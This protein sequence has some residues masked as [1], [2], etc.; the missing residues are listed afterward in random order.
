MFV[1]SSA[2]MVKFPHC[3]TMKSN[4][5][6][7][8]PDEGDAVLRARRAKFALRDVRTRAWAG[9]VVDVAATSLNRLD[10]V[11]RQ[12]VPDARV[13]LSPLAGMDIAGVVS[14]VGESVIG[15]EVGDRVV[16]DLLW[17][18]SMKIPNWPHG[19]F[20]VSRYSW[21]HLRR[22]LCTKCWFRHTYISAAAMPLEHAATFPACFRRRPR[23]LGLE[24]EG[25]GNS[26][27]SCRWLR[28]FDRR[29]ELAKQAGF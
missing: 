13:H 27:D 4:M 7:S 28:R 26:H 24:A 16:V 1:D 15:V 8:F 6:E 19:D 9:D 12:L 23:S 5:E 29:I 20:M 22:G 18:E 25:R 17:R 14:A 11:Q 2:V 3:P 21:R 10:V